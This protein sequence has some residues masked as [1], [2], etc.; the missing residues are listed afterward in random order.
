MKMKV[1]VRKGITLNTRKP[2]VVVEAKAIIFAD[3]VEIV[4]IGGVMRNLSV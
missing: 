3:Y 2:R 4:Q 1:R